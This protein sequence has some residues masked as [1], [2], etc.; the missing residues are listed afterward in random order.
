MHLTRMKR[1]P[2]VCMTQ[3][4][5]FGRLEWQEFLAQLLLAHP[6][7]RLTLQNLSFIFW[8]VVARATFTHDIEMDECEYGERATLHMR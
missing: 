4:V 3:V 6:P 5:A 8:S 1:P 2:H 7:R